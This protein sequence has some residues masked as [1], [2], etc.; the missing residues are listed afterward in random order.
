MKKLI[1]FI[2]C[3]A[4]WVASSLI[5][6][7]YNFYDNLKKPFFT[8]P[9]IF[10][11]IAWSIIYIL[12]AI[13]IYQIITTYKN[14]T[15]NSYKLT[16]IINYI[17]NQSFQIMFFLLKNTFLG[18]VSC[19]ITFISALF[20]YQETF[21]LKEKSTKFLDPYILLSLFATILSFTIY[22]LNTL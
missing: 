3:L 16:L 10:Y 22:V 1:T 9:P 12:I 6:I 21:N 13:S 18:F 8:P 19:I 7:D 20:L 2:L 15:P 14:K 11:T 17:A 5:P 4:P